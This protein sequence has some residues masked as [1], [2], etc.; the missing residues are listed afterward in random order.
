MV[1]A[2]VKDTQ[3]V[4]IASCDKCLSPFHLKILFLPTRCPLIT[5][6]PTFKLR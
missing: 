2:L 1:R 3:H 4:E 6:T 5:F